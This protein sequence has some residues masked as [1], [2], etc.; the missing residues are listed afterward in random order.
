MRRLRDDSGTGHGD[1]P[2]VELLRLEQSGQFPDEFVKIEGSQIH[3][4]TSQTY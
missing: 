2:E 1:V 3:S 4:V